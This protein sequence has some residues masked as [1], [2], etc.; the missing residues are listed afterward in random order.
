VLGEYVR[1]RRCLS[2]EAA[3][4]KMTGL[5]AKTFKLGDRGLIRL[6]FAADLTIFDPETIEDLADFHDPTRPA[7]G[8]VAV[9]LAGRLAYDFRGHVLNRFGRFIAR[10]NP[11]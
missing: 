3:I 2:L 5:S 9:Y 6:G 10:S 4:H 1:H 7:K 8:I 11:S